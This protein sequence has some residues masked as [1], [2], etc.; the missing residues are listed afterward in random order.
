MLNSSEVRHI[1]VEHNFVDVNAIAV[2]QVQGLDVQI[3]AQ[4]WKNSYEGFY[5]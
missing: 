2:V 3:I 4:G 5:Y 1:F